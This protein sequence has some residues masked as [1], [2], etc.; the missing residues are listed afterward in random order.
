MTQATAVLGYLKRKG[1]QGATAMELAGLYIPQYNWCVLWLRRH[2]HRIQ[3]L[4]QADPTTGKMR[5]RFFYKG[6]AE[7][8]KRSKKTTPK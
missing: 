2:G 1:R 3:S 6:K 7:A 8:W 4:R 5:W